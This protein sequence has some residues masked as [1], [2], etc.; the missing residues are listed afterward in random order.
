VKSASP[1][2]HSR[3]AVVCAASLLESL[4]AP[5]G[6]PLLLLAGSVAAS[7]VFRGA[8]RG[9]ERVRLL[10]WGSGWYPSA[11]QGGACSD[12]SAACRSTLTMRRP[13][14]P[15]SAGVRRDRRGRQVHSR[16]QSDGGAARRDPAHASRAVRAIDGA[17]AIAGPRP[18]S[19]RSRVRQTG[20]AARDPYAASDQHV[21]GRAPA[22]VAWKLYER[23]GSYATTPSRASRLRNCN[24]CSPR[25]RGCP[26][27][28][29]E[30]RAGV[31]PVRTNGPRG[32]AYHR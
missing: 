21:G 1:A 10:D 24:D 11:S 22:F 25:S 31:R 14:E 7:M 30:K 18:R 6:V 12:C 8:A 26:G 19:C 9:R 23:R 16:L 32:D 15:V 13:P 27:D 20:P 17:A 29:P 5:C 4:G 2:A 3:L 28:R